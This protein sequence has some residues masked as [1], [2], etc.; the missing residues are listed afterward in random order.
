MTINTKNQTKE[1]SPWLNCLT[2]LDHILQSFTY[3][4]S[5]FF[6]VFVLKNSNFCSFVYGWLATKD[7]HDGKETCVR[8]FSSISFVRF[9]LLRCFVWF[10]FTSFFLSFVGSATVLYSHYMESF[11]VFGLALAFALAV[12]VAVARGKPNVN[13][14]YWLNELLL[15]YNCFVSLS[16]IPSI[17]W[18][19]L[20]FECYPSICIFNVLHAFWVKILVL[21]LLCNSWGFS[22]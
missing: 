7:K 5:L 18:I 13:E 21:F 8:C 10:K 14:M 11:S 17:S 6:S 16:F 22:L 3:N 12:A 4:F 15:W 1:N 19:I 20:L 2:M 9:R